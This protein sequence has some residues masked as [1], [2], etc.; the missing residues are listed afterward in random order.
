MT[1]L[2]LRL[3]A[4]PRAYFWA[5]WL[6][7][8]VAS[9]VL[10]S[11][12]D[13]AKWLVKYPR[14]MFVPLIAWIND[15]KTATIDYVTP[16]TRAIA[17]LIE[18]PFDLLQALL[19]KGFITAGQDVIFPRLSWL[20]VI[21][22]MTIA[23]YALGGVRVAVVSFLCFAYLAVIGKWDSA[24]LTL[25][26]VALCVPIGIVCGLVFGIL[27]F[28]FTWLY[29]WVI[30]PSLD[31]AQTM[32]A[33]AY[34]V[35]VL[36]LFG[37]G[38]VPAMVA[39]VI[40]ATPPMVR[41][42]KLALEQVPEE[43]TSMADMFGCTRRQ[44]LWRVMLPTA[45]PL[46][47]V[48][49]NQVIMMS[50]NMVIIASMIGAGGLGFD[51][52]VALRRLDIGPAMEAG[53]AIVVIAIALDRMS[54]AA[55][56]QDGRWQAPPQGSFMQ[57]HPFVVMAAAW[58]ALTTFGGMAFD[59]LAAVP[60]ALTFSTKTMLD[61]VV[62]W[63]N[64]TFFDQIE[65]VKVWLLVNLLNP[66]KAFLLDLPWI[67]VVA[68]TGLL[69]YQ[70]GGWRLAVLVAPLILFPVLVGLWE[71]T[72]IAVYLCSISVFFAALIGIP[73]GAWA[74]TREWRNRVVTI[75]IDTLQTIPIF[76][77]IIPAVMLFGIGDVSAMIAIVLFAVTTAIRY[78][79]H[80]LRQVPPHL[81][82]AA[83]AVG[84]TQRQ[85]FWRVKLPLAMPEIM[86]GI[87]QTLLMGL[88]MLIIT[89]MIGTRDLGQE[90]FIGLAKADIGRGLVAGLCVAFLG[91]VADRLIVAGAAR[92]RRRLGLPDE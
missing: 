57:R 22:A 48:G 63:I 14:S 51:V 1:A 12:P 15:F 49:I 73:V 35:P 76:V 85:I 27:C 59:G 23:G 66:Y 3:G 4:V 88:A 86:L 89:A 68:A 17:A 55:A 9:L 24:M 30:R 77:F 64:V 44:R 75:V 26:S 2:A 67:S 10:W 41:A 37:S 72:M 56:H 79:N 70:L 74:S 40:F 16:F 33:F 43:I 18:L 61:E 42:T 20:G 84:C 87:N 29:D 28:R 8:G 50:L 71:K 38:P 69:G 7:L 92:L 53:F 81:I 78:T 91:I 60:E 25:A 19:A 45:K 39:T 32:P 47:L 34:L 65:A 21:G 62:A 52:L 6:V 11:N 31:I 13:I 82:E 80:G 46:L 36:L 58:L 83:R 90:V 5:F 54:L